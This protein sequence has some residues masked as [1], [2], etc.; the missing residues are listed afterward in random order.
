[1]VVATTGA[2]V[3]P[4]ACRSTIDLVLRNSALHLGSMVDQ[5]IALNPTFVFLENV[6]NDYLGAVPGGTVI[7]GVTVTP[8]APFTADTN[9]AL[10]KLKA[11]QPKGIVF[12][13]VDV[14]NIPFA[15]TLPP[16]LHERRQ[17][18]PEPG[19]RPADPAP[20]AE[21]L[22]DGRPRLP[23]PGHDARDAQRRGLPAFRLRHPVRGRPD[24]PEMQQPAAGGGRRGRQP[25]RPHLRGRR[26]APQAAHRRLQHGRQGGRGRDRATSITTRTNFSCA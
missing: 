10:A 11:K 18:R 24:A 19:D 2:E 25:G 15:T 9:A 3:D 5:A 16:F 22:P 4:G 1:M 7:D 6:G 20:R 12:G 8:V 17:A 21:G 23:D 26:R 13:V 14:T